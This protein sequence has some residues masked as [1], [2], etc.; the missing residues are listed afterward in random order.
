MTQP[1]LEVAVNRVL[2]HRLDRAGFTVT[3]AS[4]EH[5]V[6][7]R[8][9]NALRLDYNI[10][11]LPRPWLSVRIGRSIAPG[12]LPAFVALW[13]V[14]PND[15]ELKNPQRLLFVTQEQL[16]ERLVYFRD[17][18]V[19]TYV[20]PALTSETML[21]DALLVQE[22]ELMAEH[23]AMKREQQLKTARSLFEDKDYRGVIDAYV[24]AGLDDLAAADR[25][26]LATSRRR[27]GD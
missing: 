15:F 7:E 12:A 11:D 18:W 10:E 19:S 2:R 5:V 9:R 17:T 8:G 6:F 1:D 27:L 16:E 23:E 14:F 21:P 3:D 13:R 4:A 25:R 26:R 24:V 22:R 20:V